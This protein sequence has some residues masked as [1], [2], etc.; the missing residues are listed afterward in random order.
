MR[1]VWSYNVPFFELSA[2]KMT[3]YRIG[4]L[5]IEFLETI[6]IVVEGF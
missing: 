6:D 2:P 4:S 1:N 5:L 3:H